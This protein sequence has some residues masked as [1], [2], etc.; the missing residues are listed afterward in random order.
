MSSKIQCGKPS[1]CTCMNSC[2]R[3]PGEWPWQPGIL[4]KSDPLPTTDEVQRIYCCIQ[5]RNDNICKYWL[6]ISSRTATKSKANKYCA[7]C[8]TRHTRKITP[9]KTAG[10]CCYSSVRR[11][12]ERVRAQGVRKDRRKVQGRSCTSFRCDTSYFQH[13]DLL[14]GAIQL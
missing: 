13:Q 1:D 14:M 2:G 12:G 8:F 6:R 10:L 9:S 5:V 7:V 4:P 11:G 3:R